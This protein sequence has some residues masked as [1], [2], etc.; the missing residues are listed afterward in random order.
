[1]TL[2]KGTS[3]VWVTMTAFVFVC[4]YC[5]GQFVQGFGFF[6]KLSANYLEITN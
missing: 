1:L 4:L 2:R 5:K 6:Y 3:V